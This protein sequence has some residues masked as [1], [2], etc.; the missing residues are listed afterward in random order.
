M[1]AQEENTGLNN[2]ITNGWDGLWVTT[3]VE[4]EDDFS[5]GMD[6]SS[7]GDDTIDW[8]NVDYTVWD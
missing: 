7:G 4:G 6:D 2:D 3:F 8:G 1:I 5:G